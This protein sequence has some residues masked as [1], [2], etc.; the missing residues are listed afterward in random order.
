MKYR[1]AEIAQD[2]LFTSSRALLYDFTWHRAFRS[3]ILNVIHNASFYHKVL[4]H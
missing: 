3:G 4:L 2:C 1:V